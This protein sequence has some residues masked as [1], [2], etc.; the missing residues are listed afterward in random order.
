MRKV[1]LVDNHAE[2]S[3]LVGRQV[4][5]QKNGS[6]IRTGQ[7]EAVT[8]AADM[9]WIAACGVELRSLYEKAQGYT[10]LPTSNQ[11]VCHDDRD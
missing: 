5:I 10:V 6:T 11:A 8:V 1:A 9:L 7:V 4:S 2:W 3:D